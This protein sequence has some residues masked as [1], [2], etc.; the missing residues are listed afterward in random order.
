M[1]DT[2]FYVLEILQQLQWHINNSLFQS[3][4]TD[5]AYVSELLVGDNN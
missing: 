4:E 1:P 2:Y 3:D 5:C